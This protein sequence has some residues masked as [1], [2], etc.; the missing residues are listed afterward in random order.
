MDWCGKNSYTD[1]SILGHV[2]I[3]I[4]KRIVNG[5]FGWDHPSL[6]KLSLDMLLI[7]LW[8]LA[9]AVDRVGLGLW[10][11]FHSSPVHLAP[12]DNRSPDSWYSGGG[13][14]GHELSVVQPDGPHHLWDDSLHLLLSPLL[15]RLLSIEDVLGSCSV[16]GLQHCINKDFLL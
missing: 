9:A 3:T 1:H 4:S 12:V 14:S 5:V 10:Q 11:V 8:V 13:C 16:D 15:V 6:S 2:A 7:E